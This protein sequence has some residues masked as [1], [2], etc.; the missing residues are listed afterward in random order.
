MSGARATVIAAG[1]G[2]VASIAAAAF[3]AGAGF[4][5]AQ[6]SDVHTETGIARVLQVDLYNADAQL[7]E[8]QAGVSP[9]PPGNSRFSLAISPSDETF[10]AGRL[11]KDEWES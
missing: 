11:S 10:L 8:I 5:T 1:V 6:L 4:R 7:K 3:S 2:A 9:G